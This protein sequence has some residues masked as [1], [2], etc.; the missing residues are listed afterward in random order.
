MRTFNY[1]HRPGTP[2]PAQHAALLSKLCRKV[3]KRLRTLVDKLSLA[4]NVL[5]DLTCAA[6]DFLCTCEGAW[7]RSHALTIAHS[8]PGALLLGTPDELSSPGDRLLFTQRRALAAAM[9]GIAQLKREY[10]REVWFLPSSA[11]APAVGAA[12][13][14]SSSTH[15][16]TSAAAATSTSCPASSSTSSS[17]SASRPPTAPVCSPS[18]SPSSL[19]AEQSLAE[20]SSFP[21][22]LVSA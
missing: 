20:P 15:A 11:S 10:L 22:D 9:A 18:S 14:T 3:T 6:V 19:L 17:S 8:V 2:L 12:A 5:H 21:S 13:T 1:A 7:R 16:T 4:G